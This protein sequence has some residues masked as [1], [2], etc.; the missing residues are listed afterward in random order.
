MLQRRFMLVATVSQC[1]VVTPCM[2]QADVVGA[3]ESYVA[4]FAMSGRASNGTTLGGAMTMRVRGPRARI[5]Y[6]AGYPGMPDGSY[7]LF[8]AVEGKTTLVIPSQRAFVVFDSNAIKGIAAK[9]TDAM[10]PRFSGVSGAR[11]SLGGG[12]TILG[13]TSRR[14]RMRMGMTMHPLMAEGTNDSLMAVRTEIETETHVTDAIGPLAQGFGALS[15]GPV[16]GSGQAMMFGG[17]TAV[18]RVQALM[19]PPP[20]FPIV[21]ITKTRA[22]GMGM[23]NTMEHSMR[24]ST[25]ERVSVRAE[26]VLIPEGFTPISM[27]DMVQANVESR[28]ASRPL[29]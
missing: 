20:G 29:R 26:D 8:D 7:S 9:F 25:L 5:E 11:D 24:L 4:T 23:A 10:Q 19:M 22:V 28:P 1:L 12:E 16:A 2:A 3:P 6:P 14:Y 18:A 17:D 27:M 13:F 21:Q 15:R